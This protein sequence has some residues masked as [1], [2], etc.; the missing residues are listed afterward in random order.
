MVCKRLESWASFD[1]SFFSGGYLNSIALESKATMDL[2]RKLLNQMI[3]VVYCAEQ[4][5][6]A[7]GAD[8][9]ILECPIFPW[10]ASLSWKCSF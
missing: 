3:V 9:E 2:S 8:D 1:M 7:S 6:L 4:R 5:Y 10:C